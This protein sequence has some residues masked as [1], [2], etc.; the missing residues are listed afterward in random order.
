MAHRF[1][2]HQYTRKFVLEKLPTRRLIERKFDYLK[3]LVNL[4]DKCFCSN[5]NKKMI[6]NMLEIIK[7]WEDRFEPKSQHYK[8]IEL[9]GQRSLPNYFNFL[10]KKRN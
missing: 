9:F 3:S 8:K 5:F 4:K 6:E 1:I 7:N 10:T 2:L